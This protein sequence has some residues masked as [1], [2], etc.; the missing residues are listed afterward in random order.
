MYQRMIVA[1]QALKNEHYPFQ[2]RW[3]T[4][5]PCVTWLTGQS[6][7]QVIKFNSISSSWLL[8]CIK[9]E[10]SQGFCSGWS[11]SLLWLF[12]G[13]RDGRHRSVCCSFWWMS[14]SSGSHAQC[15][16]ALHPG[17]FGSRE[18]W[19]AEIGSSPQGQW[20]DMLCRTHRTV[21][22]CTTLHCAMPDHTMRIL[23]LILYYTVHPHL[24]HTYAF[25]FTTALLYLFIT[26]LHHTSN[27][28]CNYNRTYTHTIPI[29]CCT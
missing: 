27:Y 5:K 24:Y 25:S 17:G 14:Q 12:G 13:S 2:E 7:P 28:S 6:L 3:V 18:V 10:S 9:C 19:R 29:I 22:H 21:L 11:R 16:S 23:I 1:E 8:W 20:D 15:G 26:Y 4:F